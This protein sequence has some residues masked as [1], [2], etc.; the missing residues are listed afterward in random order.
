MKI[1]ILPIYVQEFNSKTSK[2]THSWKRGNSIMAPTHNLQ[3][4]VL[5]ICLILKS[6]EHK[7]K[8]KIRKLSVV[9]IEATFSYRTK[10]FT[11]NASNF[12][13]RC[14]REGKNVYMKKNIFSTE[15]FVLGFE[16]AN[17]FIWWWFI[18]EGVGF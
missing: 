17:P 6:P 1:C 18:C 7:V 3:V 12:Q 16:T 5:K 14:E 9:R 13:T 11:P 8:N 10:M 4:I 15:T 2:K